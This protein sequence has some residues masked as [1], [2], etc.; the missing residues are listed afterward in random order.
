MKIRLAFSLTMAGLLGLT[1]CVSVSDSSPSAP[2][3]QEQSTTESNDQTTNESGS[4][5]GSSAS[6]RPGIGQMQTISGVD[7]T[8]NSAETTVID[9]LSSSPN[10]DIY[11]V[12]DVTLQNNSSDEIALSSLLSFSLRGSD[13]YNYSVAIFVDTKG[14]LDTSVAPGDQ[15]RGQIAYDV[16]SLDYYDFSVQPS[17]FGDTGV[18]RIT[19]A[20][21]R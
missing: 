9:G 3:A 21:I 4:V 16:P 7:V 11:L 20:D 1:G 13:S 12:L 5:Q 14:S 6:D 8:V 2:P 19:D 17:L 10:E 15:V 18:F